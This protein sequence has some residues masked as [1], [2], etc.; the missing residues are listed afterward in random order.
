MVSLTL[1]RFNNLFKRWDTLNLPI[2]QIDILQGSSINE[3]LSKNKIIKKEIKS[4]SNNKFIF[5][6][7]NTPIEIKKFINSE[8]ESGSNICLYFTVPFMVSVFAYLYI[9]ST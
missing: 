9:R 5:K 6:S 8:K 7:K 1:I 3:I 4:E 2:R